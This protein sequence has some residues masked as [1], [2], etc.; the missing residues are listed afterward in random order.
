MTGVQVNADGT[1]QTNSLGETVGGK[2]NST[3]SQARRRTASATEV[4]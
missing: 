2:D 4:K 3:A 1:R